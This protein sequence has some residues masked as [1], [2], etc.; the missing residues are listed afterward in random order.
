MNGLQQAAAGQ[1]PVFEPIADFEAWNMTEAAKR[2]DT[3]WETIWDA[4]QASYDALLAG[5]DALSDEQLAFAFKTPWG[6]QVSLF[7]WLT[8]WP[9]HER[10]HAVDVRHALNLTRWPKRLAEHPDQ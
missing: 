9:L 10:E 1:T 6:S 2:K 5:L 8:I 7:R 4:Y 3:A